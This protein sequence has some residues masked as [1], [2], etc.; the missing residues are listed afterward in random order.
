MGYDG[1]MWKVRLRWTLLAQNVWHR[2]LAF[3]KTYTPTSSNK[4]AN[5][6]FILHAP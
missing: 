4:I 1:L 5:E 3:Q 6:T 2:H